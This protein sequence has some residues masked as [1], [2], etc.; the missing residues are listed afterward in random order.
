MWHG[1]MLRGRHTSHACVCGDPHVRRIGWYACND[2]ERI[3]VWYYRV[4]C[5]PTMGNPSRLKFKRMTKITSGRA[6]PTT[7]MHSHFTRDLKATGIFHQGVGP[8]EGNPSHLILNTVRI[9]SGRA[10]SIAITCSHFMQDSTATSVSHLSRSN[11]WEAISC[12]SRSNGVHAYR[13]TGVM[14]LI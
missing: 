1:H 8:M 14:M 4:N 12:G 11:G 10:D 7:I 6:N 2:A 13:R 9:T 3:V 5:D